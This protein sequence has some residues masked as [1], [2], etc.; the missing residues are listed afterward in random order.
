MIKYIL[1][2]IIQGLTEFLPVSS[3]GHLV[4]AERILGITENQI[5]LPVILHLGTAFS[6]L[7]FFSRNLLK[8]L[9]DLRLIALLCTTTII[10]VIIAL[11]GRDFFENLFS[12]VSYVAIALLI[13]G[14]ILIATKR[15]MSGQRR[16]INLK[17]ASILGLTQSIAIIPG[18]SRSGITISTLL[19]R[20][21]ERENSFYYSFLAAIPVIFGAAVL[22]MRQINYALRQDALKLSLGFCVSFL[23]G[24]ASLWILKWVLKKAKLHYFG[25]YC[26]IL[27]VITLVFL[28]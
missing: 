15:F 19:F 2:G 5:A 7:V 9:R 16:E 13:T 20:G 14:A 8:I 12:S 23:S 6:L 3:S 22:E 17:D 28:R 21:I 4:I 1:L 24:L 11:L 25:Y 26:I 18:I 27:A 10:T